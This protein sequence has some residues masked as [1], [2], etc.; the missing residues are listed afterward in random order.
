MLVAL[1]TLALNFYDNKDLRFKE[2]VKGEYL[3]RGYGEN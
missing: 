3:N 1:L 2:V